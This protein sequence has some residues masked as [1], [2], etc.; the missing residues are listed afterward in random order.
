MFTEK[1]T[2]SKI[3][4]FSTITTKDFNIKNMRRRPEKKG[5]SLKMSPSNKIKEYTYK[6]FYW[7]SK[8]LAGSRKW[9][10]NTIISP[11]DLQKFTLGM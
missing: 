5:S 7:D 11:W 4:N 3:E 1:Y 6:W 2:K 10:E 8:L 9:T